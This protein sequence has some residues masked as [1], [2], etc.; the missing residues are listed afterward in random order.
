MTKNEPKGGRLK[1]EFP[2]FQAPSGKKTREGGRSCNGV[3][4]V[5]RHSRKGGKKGPSSLTVP[6]KKKDPFFSH[7]T[8]KRRLAGKR[9]SSPFCPAFVPKKTLGGKEGNVLSVRGRK[10]SLGWQGVKG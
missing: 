7:E 1:K 10:S 6:G 9:P 5:T 4:S 3:G 8:A 2:L